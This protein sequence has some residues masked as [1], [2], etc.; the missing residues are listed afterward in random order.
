MALDPLDHQGNMPQL[1]TS[2]E[3][4]HRHEKRLRK[5]PWHRRGLYLPIPYPC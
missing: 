4:C 1:D 5:M 3:F 2:E